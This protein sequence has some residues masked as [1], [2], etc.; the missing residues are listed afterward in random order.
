[1][2]I[3]QKRTGECQLQPAQES[4]SNLDPSISDEMENEVVANTSKDAVQAALFDWDLSPIELNWMPR[5]S[6]ISHCKRKIQQEN[7]SLSKKIA[8]AIKVDES[9]LLL[10]SQKE[11]AEENDQKASDLYH[12]VH[13]MKEKL[14]T[15]TRTPKIKIL[16]LTPP[17]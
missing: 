3:L 11:A 7:S 14:T 4:S 5:P 1:M 12:L 6:I 8:S 15:A 2:P 16:T 10:K 9:L 13:L 17:S